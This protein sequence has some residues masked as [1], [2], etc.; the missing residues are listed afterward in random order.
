M[1]HPPGSVHVV[2]QILTDFKSGKENK[3]IFWISGFQ[4]DR[5]IVIEYC[6]VRGKDNE[7]LGVLEVTQDITK[8]R[9]LEGNQRLL[10]YEKK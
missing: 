9:S 1:C 4:K 3:A 8:L 10:S 2:E 7:Y 6:A 5:F